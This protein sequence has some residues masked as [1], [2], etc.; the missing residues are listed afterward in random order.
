MA[1]MLA[2]VAAAAIV[3]FQ[4]PEPVEVR[5]VWIPNSYSSFFQSRKNVE[6]Q[7]ALLAEA[8]V[9][10]DLIF[11]MDEI[12]DDFGAVD[13]A[14]VI[15]AND[16]VNPAAR[17]D[18]ASPIYGMPILNVDRAHQ[19]YVIKRGQGKGYAGVDNL[20]FGLD[21]CAIHHRPGAT[22]EGAP[23]ITCTKAALADA[24]KGAVDVDGFLAIESVSASDDGP[25]RML[26]ENLDQ[27]SSE[28]GIVEP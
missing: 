27:F 12:N 2:A 20:L 28:F 13:V 21:N 1:A 9:P 19:V 26:F 14:L 18:K 6:T 22:I 5:G 3:T 24:V 23:S 15:G 4:Q 25:V 8:G 11:D 17:T 7:M 10:Y 16:V